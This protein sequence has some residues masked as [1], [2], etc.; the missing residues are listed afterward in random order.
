MLGARSLLRLA[1]GLAVSLL[2]L[3]LLLA[4]V[5]L[6]ELWGA[7]GAVRAGWVG[8]AVPVY[9]LALWTRAERWRLV[10]APAMRV[11]S[12]DAASLVV[13]GYTANNLLPA[14]AGE[15]VRAV[16]LQRRAGGSRLTALGTIVVER[17]FDGLVLALFLPL[18]LLLG[19][20]T[21]VLRALAAAGGAAFLVATVALAALAARPAAM[22][23]LVHTLLGLAPGGVRPALRAWSASFL[24]GLGLLRGPRA[25]AAVT[26]MTALSWALEAVAYAMI[27]AAFGLGIAPWLYLGVAGAANL[28]ISAPTAAGGVGPFEF[29]AR[30]VLVVF[31]AGVTAATAYALVL[32][33]FLLVPT[34]LVGLA[35]LWREHLSI[36]AL[37]RE[38]AAAAADGLAARGAA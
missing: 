16:L 28:A 27:G 1:V 7:I 25:W 17:V 30:E 6:D 20:S 3:T 18:P 2:F 15:V 38:A 14:R 31:G 23:R 12:R 22:E 36:G 32:H 35:L 24:A 34:T 4:R 19:G 11:R 33:G 26:G 21:G 8:L 9:A 5:D 10:L 13:I 29:F 37:R